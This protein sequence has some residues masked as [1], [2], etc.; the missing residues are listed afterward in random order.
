M[1]LQS[2]AEPVDHHP[3]RVVVSAAGMVGGDQI[4]DVVLSDTIPL[5]QQL[6]E[7]SELGGETENPFDLNEL[8]AIRHCDIIDNT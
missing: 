3:V 5:K 8:G 4:R 2:F 6:H 1:V 7:P